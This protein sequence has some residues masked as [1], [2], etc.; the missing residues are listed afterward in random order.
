MRQTRKRKLFGRT[1]DRCY[2]CKSKLNKDNRTLDHVKPRRDGGGGDSSNLQPCCLTCNR[3]KGNCECILPTY[4]LTEKQTEMLV[5][6]Y[7]YFLR[8]K[9]KGKP[10]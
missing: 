7:R 1:E 8:L 2:I 9:F 3:M 10:K 5:K 4:R 6:S